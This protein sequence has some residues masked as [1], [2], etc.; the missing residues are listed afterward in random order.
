[1]IPA[2]GLCYRF[3]PLA[4]QAAGGGSG[5]ATLAGKSG[6]AGSAHVDADKMG[7]FDQETGRPA[8]LQIDDPAVYFSSMTSIAGTTRFS[9]EPQQ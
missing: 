2:A 8:G 7:L 6:T 3:K 5:L 1:L 9:Q 4:L